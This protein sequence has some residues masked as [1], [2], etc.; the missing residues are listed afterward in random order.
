[1][2]R[3]EVLWAG[4][5]VVQPQGQA[6]GARRAGAGTPDPREVSS[7]ERGDWGLASNS[8]TVTGEP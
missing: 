2:K 1:M 5:A 7:D 6:A 8:C 4:D 3:G